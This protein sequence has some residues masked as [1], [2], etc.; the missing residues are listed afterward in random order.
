MGGASQP[1]DG[2]KKVI[3]KVSKISYID[4]K[5]ILE[6]IWRAEGPPEC[7]YKVGCKDCP[8]GYLKLKADNPKGFCCVPCK[9]MQSE[10]SQIKTLLRQRNG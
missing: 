1:P 7:I 4:N 2:K 5:E 9:D 8:E 3:L 6:E 10:V